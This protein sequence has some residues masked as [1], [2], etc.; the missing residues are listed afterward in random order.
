MPL[1]VPAGSM[2][3][4]FSI[5]TSTVNYALRVTFT[6][7]GSGLTAEIFLQPTNL[8]V[9]G[10]LPPNVV[11]LAWDAQQTTQYHLYRAVYPPSGAANWT[12]V[13][14]LDGSALAYDDAF[15]FVPGVAYVYVLTGDQA[16]QYS[17]DIVQPYFVPATA[18]QAV[19]SRLDLRY[20][21]NVLLDRSFGGGAYR[22]GLFA[23]MAA[24]PSRVGRSFAKF[25][26]DSQPP[27]TL[28]FFRVGSIAAYLTKAYT[29][30]Q[31]A[32]TMQVGCQ[33]LSDT[34][35]DAPSL[36]WSTA[37]A[38]DPSAASS[39]ATVQYD[40]SAPLP[41]WLQWP[42]GE[43]IKQASTSQTPFAVAWTS[44]NEGSFGWAYFAKKE[45]D[46]T[47]APTAC[48]AWCGP[49][50]LSLTL[51]PATLTSGQLTTAT[52][53]VNG[54]GPGDSVP[55]Y[56]WCDQVS[57]GVN[58]TCPATMTLTGLN[59]T[60][61]VGAVAGSGY[62]QLQIHASLF[63]RNTYPAN[64]AYFRWFATAQLTISS[65]GGSNPPGGNVPAGPGG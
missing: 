39:F 26:F 21:T 16:V 38:A 54:I 57:E 53:N 35:W 50:V 15:S 4:T 8:H 23:G 11:Q 65:G 37:P 42:L 24:D 10:L 46:P 58:Y 41:Q 14:T 62:G 32:V 34:T 60:F 49:T 12:L 20:A 7:A 56:L 13:A 5:R 17:A 30:G 19:D 47:K 31:G 18:N 59:R 9:V 6:E 40:P 27:H 44:R 2:S 29:R 64:N 55:I 22:G 48:C 43:A 45:F 61:T 33:P 3:V 28:P 63:P 51:S 52:I 36:K 25:A 1:V